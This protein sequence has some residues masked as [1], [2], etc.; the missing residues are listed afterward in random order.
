SSTAA[1]RTPDMRIDPVNEGATFAQP[2]FE[3][4]TLFTDPDAYVPLLERYPRLRVCLAHF[5]G[6]GDWHRFIERPGQTGADAATRSWLSKILAMLTSGRYPNLWTDIAYTLFDN[7]DYVYLL[8]DLLAD[9][10]VASRVLFGSDLYVVENAP[11]EER[12][13]SIRIRAIL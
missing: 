8:K 3:L 13:R 5:G 10:T 11:L 9:E 1:S 12:S 4:L 6:G 2:R 7:D